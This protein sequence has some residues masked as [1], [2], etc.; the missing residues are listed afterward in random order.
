[1]EGR[2]QGRSDPDLSPKGVAQSL[3]LLEQLKDRPISAIYTSTLQRS[4]LTAQPIA[5]HFGLSIRRQPELDEIAFG[6]LEGKQI[7]DSDEEVK[8]EWERFKENRFTYH[9]PKAENYTDVINRIRPFVEKILQN[10]KGEE[11]LIVGHR[12]VNQ[13]LIGALMNYPPEEMLKIQQSNGCFYLIEKNAE[14]KVFHYNHGE[15]RE[16]FLSESP[17]KMTVALGRPGGNTSKAL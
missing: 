8:S 9:I 14:T 11:I 12:V 5:S 6:I 16:G 1:V 4:V 2:I 17:I 7:L 15:V 3:A 10:H 13:M